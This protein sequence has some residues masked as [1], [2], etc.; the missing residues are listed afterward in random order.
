MKKSILLLSALC[1]TTGVW[2][3]KGEPTASSH[4][5]FHVIAEA[6]KKDRMNDDQAKKAE[7]FVQE[8]VA[9]AIEQYP[10]VTKSNVFG[11]CS[12]S[13]IVVCKDNYSDKSFGF[14]VNQSDGCIIKG[15]FSNYTKAV[16]DQF[17]G[18]L[19]KGFLNIGLDKYESKAAWPKGE[20]Y[21]DG[22][23]S[24]KQNLPKGWFEKVGTVFGDG[25]KIIK[26]AAH[27][28]QTS[29][30]GGIHSAASRLAA[31]TQ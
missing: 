28:V 23:F 24:N 29:V 12:R 21:F 31:S 17:K 25:G 2:A 14:E 3:K 9:K 20:F 16:C 10:G 8:A 19:E 27:D 18:T 7:E 13:G 22:R 1:M 11:S 30:K 5:M 26:D 4:E 6:Q 15:D